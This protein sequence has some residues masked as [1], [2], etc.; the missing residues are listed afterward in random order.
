[1]TCD[2]KN[3]PEI[4]GTSNF[5]YGKDIHNYDSP[6][7]RPVSD[8]YTGYIAKIREDQRRNEEAGIFFNRKF[9]A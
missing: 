9:L 7:S 8:A 3:E 2:R 1:M 5:S 6:A 4:S